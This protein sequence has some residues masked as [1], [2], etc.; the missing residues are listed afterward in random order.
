MIAIVFKN[1]LPLL[2]VLYYYLMKKASAIVKGLFAKVG[3]YNALEEDLRISTL[4]S[5]AFTTTRGEERGFIWKM[6]GDEEKKEHMILL[7]SKLSS[8][9]KKLIMSKIKKYY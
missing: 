8:T 2:F 9:I 5:I 1:E 4:K 6:G 7:S 3:S